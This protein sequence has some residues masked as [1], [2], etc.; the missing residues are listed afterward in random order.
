MGKRKQPNRSDATLYCMEPNA[1]GV[2]IGATEAFVAVPPDRDPQPIRSFAAFTAD[3]HRLADWLRECNIDTVA[4]ESTGVYWIPLFQI[5]ESR[6]FRVCLVNARH[7]KH[8]PGRKTDVSDSQWLQHLHSVGLLRASFRPPQVICTVRSVVRHRESLIQA[9]AVHIQHVQ[10]ALDQMNL[11]LHHVISDITGLTGMAILDR[12]LAGERDAATLAKLRDKRIRAS[13]ATIIKSL[14]GDYRR[15]HLFTLRQSLA[16]YRYHQTLIAECDQEIEQS[17]AV[18]ESKI[19]VQQHQLC[20]PKDRHRPRRNELRF[21]VRRELFRIFGVDL[22]A[23]PSINALTAHTL[24]TEI[25]PDLSKF[26]NCAAFTSWLGLCPD[27]RISGGKMLSA[28]TRPVKNRAS[29]ALR[30][31]A[32]SLHRDQ[33]YLGQFFRRMR[34]KLGAPKAI[35]ATA[36]KLARVVFHLL[37]TRQPYEESQFAL[38]ELQHRARLISRLKRRAEQLGFELNPKPVAPQACVPWES[39]EVGQAALTKPSVRIRP[40][41]LRKSRS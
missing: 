11:R 35:T 36:H 30:M 18:I 2:D 20:K 39:I 7:A 32:Q 3:L 16:A 38:Q 40:S 9:A 5:L 24:L 37:S 12:I 13:E 27:N 26:A 6:G 4:M 22:T 8:V 23:I 31:A 29:I 19:D 41:A 33:S 1:A 17:L 14:T 10:K 21:D 15:E 25:G 34:A 28:K